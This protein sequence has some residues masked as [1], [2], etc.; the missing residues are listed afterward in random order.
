MEEEEEE[1]EEEE[2]SST[3]NW[4]FKKKKW[5]E[6]GAPFSFQNPL[7]CNSKLSQWQ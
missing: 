5:L 7:I 6:N 4:D 3:T 2:D 1:E